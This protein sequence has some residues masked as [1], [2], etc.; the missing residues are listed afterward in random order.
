MSYIIYLA[1]AL[2]LAYLAWGVLYQLCYALAG[3]GWQAPVWPPAARQRKILVLIPAYREDTVIIN[4]A[5]VATQQNYPA[6][7]FEVIVIADSLKPETLAA[8]REIPVRVE[9]VHF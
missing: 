1:G 8:L 4:T 9:E 5:R 7:A 2:L 6:A 3:L